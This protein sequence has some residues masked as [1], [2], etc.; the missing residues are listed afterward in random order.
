VVAVE[1]AVDGEA[2]VEVEAENTHTAGSRGKLLW[3]ADIGRAGGNASQLVE[4][5]S[6]SVATEL[7]RGCVSVDCGASCVMGRVVDVDKEDALG[8]A[9]AGVGS[10]CTLSE[11][12]G[13]WEG[14]SG[15]GAD[16][17]R[18]GKVASRT[19]SVEGVE[20]AVGEAGDADD[21]E[22]VYVD[23]AVGREEGVRREA[24]VGER[25]AGTG[26]GAGA[27]TGARMGVKRAGGK[28]CWMVVLL[29]QVTAGAMLC[30][31]VVSLG[32]AAGELS[33]AL[34]EAGAV[35]RLGVGV[36]V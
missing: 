30:N 14:E 9:S 1:A 36:G 16:A 20:V 18:L 10:R 17:L 26:A 7:R 11:V 15:R 19:P 8:L 33:P 28:W 23:K 22:G 27:G 4:D 6:S 24:C 13:S 12:V 2:D 29:A 21:T 32:C 31:T 35:G 5:C 3:R 25:V 34:G